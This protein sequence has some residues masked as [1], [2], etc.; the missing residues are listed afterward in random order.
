[1]IDASHANSQ[2]PDRQ[3]AVVEDIASQ[4]E[5]GAPDHWTDAGKLLEARRQDVV[6]KDEL[7]GKSTRSVYGL[8]ALCGDAGDSGQC[9]S[10]PSRGLA[11]RRNL[12]GQTDDSLNRP[13]GSMTTRL[14]TGVRP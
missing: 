1:M 6:N 14:R 11:H 2:Q 12:H 7:I 9:G 5:R 8:A 10:E 3:V 13:F 4:V